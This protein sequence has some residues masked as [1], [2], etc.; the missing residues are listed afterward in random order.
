MSA[1]TFKQQQIS[2]SLHFAHAVAIKN[3]NQ[4]KIWAL[5]ANV[6]DI[7]AQIKK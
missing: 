2:Y 5:V 4:T 6:C 7:L 1:L 3:K